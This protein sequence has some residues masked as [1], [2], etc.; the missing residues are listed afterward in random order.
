VQLVLP[1]LQQ[2]SPV[3]WQDADQLSDNA[4]AI[5]TALAVV[6][7]AILKMHPAAAG[8]AGIG[9]SAAGVVAAGASPT[10]GSS[11]SSNVQGANMRE[12]LHQPLQALSAAVT[13]ALQGLQRANKIEQ[14][15]LASSAA[16]APE[17]AAAGASGVQQQQQQERVAIPGDAQGAGQAVDAWL[18]VSRVQDVLDRVLELL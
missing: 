5:C 17:A 3:G 14:G 7:L 11:S 15:G 10:T 18:A 1:W 6:R 16:A 13:D 12:L 8:A 2:D 9:G 4:N